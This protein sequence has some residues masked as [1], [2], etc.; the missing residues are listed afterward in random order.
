MAVRGGRPVPPRPDLPAFRVGTTALCAGNTNK[1]AHD[2]RDTPISVSRSG[3]FAYRF[4]MARAFPRVA[5][6]TSGGGS[7]FTPGPRPASGTHSSRSRSPAASGFPRAHGYGDP[8]GHRGACPTPRAGAPVPATRSS[9]RQHDAPHRCP[10]RAPGP[11]LV[12]RVSRQASDQNRIRSP[13]GKPHVRRSGTSA[14]QQY[15]R[16]GFEG[17]RFVA[18]PIANRPRNSVDSG[19][20]RQDRRGAS[21]VVRLRLRATEH[22]RTDSGK[23]WHEP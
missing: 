5:A 6:M 22:P 12:R 7:T 2:G 23:P 9:G 10:A 11:P 18:A 8:T 15:E 4:A 16:A 14:G 21:G 20:F 3:C 1:P 13:S 19:T 17:E